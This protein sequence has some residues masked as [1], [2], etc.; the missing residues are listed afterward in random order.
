MCDYRKIPIIAMMLT[1]LILPIA[2]PVAWAAGEEGIYIGG[3]TPTY[4]VMKEILRSDE[5]LKTLKKFLKEV[6]TEEIFIVRNGKM[7]SIDEIL[8][9]HSYYNYDPNRLEPVYTRISDGSRM[10]IN[11]KNQQ[12]DSEAPEII[13]IR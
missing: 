13:Y 1:L 2:I 12:E 3:D 11:G 8:R 10:V 6:D 9:N 4:F 5:Q 7:A